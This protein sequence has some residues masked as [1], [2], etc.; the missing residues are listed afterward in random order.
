L[1]DFNFHSS[2]S[3]S[4]SKISPRSD[5]TALILKG[6]VKSAVAVPPIFVAIAR[7]D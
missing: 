5:S 6:V 3:K 1:T 4:V 2:S 7:V